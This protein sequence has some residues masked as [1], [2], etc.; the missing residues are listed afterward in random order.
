MPQSETKQHSMVLSLLMAAAKA[1]VIAI[2]V[3]M[4]VVTLAQVV[5]RYVLSAPLPWSEELARYCFVWIVFLGGAIGLERGIHLGV[6]L[7]VNLL[8]PKLRIGLDVLSSAMIGCFAAAV[9]YASFPVIEMNMLQ[10]SP[11]MGVQMSWIYIAIP[12]SMALIFLISVERIAKTL[13]GRAE[14]EV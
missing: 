4:V 14:R 3:V 2:S 11:A 9:I 6:D 1:S 7:F 13:W 12:T 10:R 8:P 5:F